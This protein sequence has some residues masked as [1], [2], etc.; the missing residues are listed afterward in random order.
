M[1][2]QKPD[3][4]VIHEKSLFLQDRLLLAC[5]QQRFPDGASISTGGITWNKMKYS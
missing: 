2:C 1:L 3:V 5:V 4:Y